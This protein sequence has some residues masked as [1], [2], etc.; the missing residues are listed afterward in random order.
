[1]FTSPCKNEVLYLFIHNNISIYKNSDNVQIDV[2]CGGLVCGQFCIQSWGPMMSPPLPFSPPLSIFLS[3]STLAPRYT[4]DVNHQAY[5]VTDSI[6]GPVQEHEEGHP[7]SAQT[8]WNISN[9]MIC[10]C[11]CFN[12]GV[13]IWL[14]WFSKRGPV[15]S[16]QNFI[17]DI[18]YIGIRIYLLFSLSDKCN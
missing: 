8:F 11:V 10:V 18:C 14:I 2:F 3:L 12:L 1:M 6:N 13:T 17:T 7:T 16:E 4:S 9:M 5:W 15:Q